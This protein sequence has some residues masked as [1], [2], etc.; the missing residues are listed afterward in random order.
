MSLNNKLTS[1]KGLVAQAKDEEEK[2][3]ITEISASEIQVLLDDEV[4]SNKQDSWN[5]LSKMIKKQKLD[6]FAERY[7]RTHELNEELLEDLRLFFKT[8][9]DNQKLQKVKEVVY[10]RE[11]QTI[12]DIP[13]LFWNPI[14]NQFKLR[15]TEKRTSTVKSLAPKKTG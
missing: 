12:T 1:R 7:I 13:A 11:A 10:D 14:N 6:E 2:A 8:C 3:Q 9:L 4:Q 5:K 15:N